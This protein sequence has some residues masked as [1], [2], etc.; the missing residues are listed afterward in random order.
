MRSLLVLTLVLLGGCATNI[1]QSYIGL[2]VRQ[3][4]VKRGPPASVMD[5][6][7]GRRAFQWAIQESVFVPATTTTY[8]SANIY[9]NTAT[10]NQTS[11][12]VGGGTTNWTCHYTLYGR[13]SEQQQ[14]WIVE[15]FEKPSWDCL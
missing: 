10:F 9:G 8:G 7:D 2:D 6:G 12:T 5:M 15:S 4:A 3:V 11:S 13:W 1:M 14:G